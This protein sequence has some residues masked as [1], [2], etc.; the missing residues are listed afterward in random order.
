M[1]TSS[2]T[3]SREQRPLADGPSETDSDGHAPSPRH[4]DW[5]EKAAYTSCFYPWVV[6]LSLYFTW[7]AA[8]LSLRHRPQPSIDDP[9]FINDAVGTFHATTWVLLVV[10]TPI[11]LI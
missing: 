2:T 9:K 10:S 7:I 5:L 8:W 4:M 6:L 3:L 1:G 11:A